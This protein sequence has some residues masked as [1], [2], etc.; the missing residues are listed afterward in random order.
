MSVSPSLSHESVW[1]YMIIDI[2]INT[3]DAPTE[4][5]VGGNTLWIKMPLNI[6]TGE[7]IS[8]ILFIFLLLSFILVYQAPHLSKW[9]DY[10]LTTSSPLYQPCRTAPRHATARNCLSCQCR[11]GLPYYHR[12]ISPPSALSSPIKP[13]SRL[14]KSLLFLQ[15][16]FSFPCFCYEMQLCSTW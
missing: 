13:P 12:G 2:D 6:A 9:G 5:M 11:L 3:N 10:A 15:C 14:L 4:Y 7:I 16:V 1:K 8:I